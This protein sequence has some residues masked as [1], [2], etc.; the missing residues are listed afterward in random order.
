MAAADLSEW[1]NFIKNGFVLPS[2]TSTVSVP[3]M[4]E[5][6]DVLKEASTLGIKLEPLDIVAVAKKIFN[7]NLID[8]KD[9][10]K[11][12]S[13][14]LE[15]INDKW[16]IYVNKYENEQRKR[17]TIAHEI[18]HFV[19][20][21]DSYFLNNNYI[22]D[23]IFFRD[24]NTSPME[25]EAN[26]FASDLL[27]PEDVFNRYIREGFNTISKLADKFKLS[28]SAVKYRAYKL[29]LISEYN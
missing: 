25:R 24:E 19:L 6:S 3:K 11:S 17:F 18:G 12:V 26:N 8:N 1:Q 7:M 21:K 5:P 9:L 2:V 23:Q 16:C 13:G 20:H 28:T 10:G 29:G 22:Y 15:K 27:M 4:K 14:F